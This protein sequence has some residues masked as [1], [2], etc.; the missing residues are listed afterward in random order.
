MDY[1]KTLFPACTRDNRNG[2]Y[3][4]T[5]IDHSIKRLDVSNGKTEYI[6]NP[7]EYKPRQWKGVDKLFFQN[8][9]LYLFEQGGKKLLQYN[10]LDGKSKC[11]ELDYDLNNCD[12]WAVVTMYH[13]TMFAVPSFAN[14]IIKLHVNSGA[15]SSMELCSDIDYQ[16]DSK[17]YFGTKDNI[18]MPYKLFSCGCRIKKD[19][20]LFTETNQYV[21]RYD[22]LEE[23]SV[24]Y[25]LPDEIRGCVHAVWNEKLF[26]ILDLDGRVY[27]WDYLSNKTE[28]IFDCKTPKPYPYFRKLVIT[29]KNIW[30]VPFT[31]KDIYIVRLEDGKESVFN[32]FPIDFHYFED[33]GRSKYYDYGE[34]EEKYYF[35]MH[36][37]N[38]MLVIRKVNGEGYW[39]KPIE[40]AA[41]ECLRYYIKNYDT[42][43]SEKEWK[44]EEWIKA[45]VEESAAT[46]L[47]G[48][49]NI[50]ELIWN[51]IKN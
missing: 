23:K 34:D 50:G 45:N 13:D 41:E 3:Y 38:Y 31:G 12:N 16:F 26:Y 39:L 1:L 48:I 15:E 30:I 24:Q 11:F 22:L 35:T 10:V 19:I 44:L 40:P 49:V 46:R 2:L 32:N 37:V 6:D 17:K 4:V 14:R 5:H 51:N 18:I 33:D 20:W 25:L 21:V 43:F 47:N 28:I 29:S 36:S 9:F 8:D 27:S 7:G 42:S